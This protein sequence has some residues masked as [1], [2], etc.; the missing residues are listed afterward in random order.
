MHC[1][2]LIP[3]CGSRFI[4][5]PMVKAQSQAA[6]DVPPPGMGDQGPGNGAVALPQQNLGDEGLEALAGVGFALP[7]AGNEGRD[8]HDHAPPVGPAQCHR[9]GPA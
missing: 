2:K 8:H 5:G 6:I 3:S 1:V 9:A 7:P 4:V